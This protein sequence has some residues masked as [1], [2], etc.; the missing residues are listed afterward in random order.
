MKVTAIAPSAPLAPFVREFTVIET[1]E[2]V[3]RTLM[4]N[5]GLIV[6]FRFGG[7]ARQLD[8]SPLAPFPHATIA[9]AR[10]TARRMETSAGGGAIFAAF[11]EGGA[12]HFF[13]E[14][15]H[16]LFADTR[17]LDDL[18]PHRCVD[19]VQSRI[20]EADDRVAVFEEF[21]LARKRERAIDSIVDAAIHAIR[22]THGALRIRDLAR[23][24]GISQDPLE[25][26]FRAHVGTSPKQLASIL[27]L[28][29]AIAAIRAG[30]SLTR[31]SIDAGY[32]D[33]SHFNREFRAMTGHSPTRLFASGETC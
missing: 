24:L 31:A 11:H 3:V 1:D 5:A 15:L 6:G 9:G 19:E 16:E 18:V 20:A 10:T 29:R 27:R 7:S 28:Q 33:Q 32:F 4:P 2:E 17:S 8:R 12:A 26:R 21:L 25:K 13:A 30:S 23:H 14:P 22:R